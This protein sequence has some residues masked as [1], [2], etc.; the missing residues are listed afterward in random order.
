MA[1]LWKTIAPHVTAALA[2]I[3]P[4]AAAAAVAWLRSFKLRLAARE[5]AAEVERETEDSGEELRGEQKMQRAVKKARKRTDASMLTRTMSDVK[6]RDLIEKELPAVK[7]D[8][9][10]P[11]K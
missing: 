7:R 4:A 3:I 9:E 5:A 1:E 10:R 2:L 6:V 11:T 8:S